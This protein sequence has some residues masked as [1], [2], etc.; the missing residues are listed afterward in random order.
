M[1]K[2]S[3]LEEELAFQIKAI[4][5][6]EPE[7]EYQFYPK[8]KFRADFAWIK[9]KLLVEVEGGIWSKG[10][11]ARPRGILRDMEKG[12][13]AALGG[14]MYLRVSADDIKELRAIDLIETAL[15]LKGCKYDK[16]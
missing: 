6:P 12:N 3:Q 9:Q 1:V 13:L 15:K 14:W 8:R 10:A 2:L 5:L 16:S 4:G 7:R 11:H